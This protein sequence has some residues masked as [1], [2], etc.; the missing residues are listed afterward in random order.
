MSLIGG[1]LGRDS[2]RWRLIRRYRDPIT[3]LIDGDAV[4]RELDYYD[5][6]SSPVSVLVQN[7][8]GQMTRMSVVNNGNSLNEQAWAERQLA[9]GIPV[10]GILGK[11]S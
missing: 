3:G 11:L 2:A 7:T 10:S 5:M 4:N 9:A 8:V 1:P 6:H